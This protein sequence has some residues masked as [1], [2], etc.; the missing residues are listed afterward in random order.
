MVNY[1]W[2]SYIIRISY[3]HMVSSDLS[4]VW[5]SWFEISLEPPWQNNKQIKDLQKTESRW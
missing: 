3:T 4:V 2:A 1:L 5:E